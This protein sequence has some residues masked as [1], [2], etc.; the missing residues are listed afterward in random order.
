M[1]HADTRMT[2][3]KRRRKKPRWLERGPVVVGYEAVRIVRLKSSEL[4][5]EVW[6]PERHSWRQ[7]NLP[8]DVVLRATP[9]DA[10]FLETINLSDADI[11]RPPA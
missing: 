7:A 2:R 4:R 1:L 6:Q 3:T 10:E 11:V 9:A 8:S 5:T